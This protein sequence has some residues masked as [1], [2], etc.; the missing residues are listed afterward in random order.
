MDICEPVDTSIPVYYPYCGYPHG[1]VTGTHVSYLSNEVGTS[2]IL[3]VYLWIIIVIPI[4]TYLLLMENQIFVQFPQVSLA[5]ILTS[6]IKR[7]NCTLICNL[8]MIIVLSL[9]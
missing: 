2:I 7:K 5:S 1:Y 9:V 3:L 6:D 8:L 4:G